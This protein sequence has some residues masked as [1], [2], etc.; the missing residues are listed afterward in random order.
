MKINKNIIKI[1]LFLIM[2]CITFSVTSGV[3]ALVQR[4]GYVNWGGDS[5]KVGK[6]TADGQIAFCIDH[7]LDSASFM[8]STA[9]PYDDA[10]IRRTLYYGWEG[11]EV[12]SGFDNNE[13]KGI[14]VTS[15]ALDHFH[16]GTD[17]NKYPDMLRNAIQDFLN[18]INNKPDPRQRKS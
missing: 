4:N 15:L 13:E 12:W 5:R 8:E 7:H 10:R 2:F 17:I 11:Q 3:F 6:Y 16:N 1:T 9:S 14:T 18:Y